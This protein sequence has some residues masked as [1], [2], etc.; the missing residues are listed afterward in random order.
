MLLC[1]TILGTFSPCDESKWLNGSVVTRG[2][3]GQVSGGLFSWSGV[4]L[5]RLSMAKLYSH[6][7][8]PSPSKGIVCSPWSMDLIESAKLVGPWA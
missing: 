2:E 4:S 8:G 5:I 1:T 7:S 6:V 3:Y